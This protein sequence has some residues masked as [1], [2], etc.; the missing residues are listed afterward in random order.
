MAHQV[1]RVRVLPWLLVDVER[2]HAELYDQDDDREHGDRRAG[3]ADLYRQFRQFRLEHALLLL[4]AA[5]L[6]AT[7]LAATAVVILTVHLL[8]AIARHLALIFSGTIN[9]AVALWMRRRRRRDVDNREREKE[10]KKKI[11][12]SIRRVNW[13]FE[14]AASPACIKHVCAFLQRLSFILIIGKVSRCSCQG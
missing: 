1:A 5:L 2:L 11:E 12:F 13:G 6:A 7:A 3:V 4:A 9:F 10:G 14:V 8:V